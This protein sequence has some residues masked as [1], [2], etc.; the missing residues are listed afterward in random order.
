MATSRD[1]IGQELA[2]HPYRTGLVAG[3]GVLSAVT[4]WTLLGQLATVLWCVG[5]AVFLAMGLH[6]LVRLVERRGVRRPAAAVAVTGAVLLVL[7]GSLLL[8][9]PALLEQAGRLADRAGR[10]AADG[11]LDPVAAGLQRLVPESVVDVRALLQ[12][13]VEGVTAGTTLPAAQGG[14]LAIGAAVGNAAFATTVVVV[15]TAYFLISYRWFAGQ[16]VA[17]LPRAHRASG[18][19]ALSTVGDSVGRYFAG[20]VWLAVLNGV[21]SLAVLLATGAAFPVLFAALAGVATL[22]PLVGIAASAAVIVAA[23]A[24]ITPERPAVWLVLAGWYLAYL[25]IEAYVISP[26][27]ARRTVAIPDVVAVLVTLAGGTLFGITGALLAVPAAV[28]VQVGV[29][30]VRGAR[31]VACAP[32]TGAPAA[33]PPPAARTPSRT[34]G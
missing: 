33:S 26:Q 19:A 22:V 12:G 11:G 32:A 1:P 6:P 20:Q 21:L 3:L 10:L 8:I 34:P 29:R 31:R 17:L 5:V 16:L 24:L 30:E 7:G 27:V 25:F 28:A 9:L 4:L 23:Q 13:A 14:M 2:R 15:L 18:T